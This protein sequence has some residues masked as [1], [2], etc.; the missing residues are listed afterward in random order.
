MGSSGRRSIKQFKPNK[1]SVNFDPHNNKTPL[2]RGE[3]QMAAS[4][5]RKCAMARQ[6]PMAAIGFLRS[7]PIGVTSALFTAGNRDRFQAA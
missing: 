7:E 5:D 4:G 3:A 2:N 6:C 1:R